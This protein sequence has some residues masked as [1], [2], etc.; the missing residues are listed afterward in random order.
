MARMEGCVRFS[1][2]QDSAL[3]H[4]RTLFRGFCVAAFALALAADA[5]V[6]QYRVYQLRSTTN[7]GTLKVP[8]LIYMFF[9]AL[10]LLS[11]F[12]RRSEAKSMYSPHVQCQT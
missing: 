6:L 9:K 5:T 7:I 1:L 4:I 2:S 11:V 10:L 3:R 8:V 12:K